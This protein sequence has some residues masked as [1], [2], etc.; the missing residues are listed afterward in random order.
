MFNLDSLV[1]LCNTFDSMTWKNY[2]DRCSLLTQ[3]T[4]L[5]R[6]PKHGHL[7]LSYRSLFRP[8]SKHGTVGC[9]QN[10]LFSFTWT[11]LYCFVRFID[12]FGILL[13]Y[14]IFHL[15]GLIPYRIAA[16]SP[17]SQ[18]LLPH[19]MSSHIFFCSFSYKLWYNYLRNRRKQVKGRVITDPGYEDVNNAFERAL[20]FMHKVR[21]N[22][23]WTIRLAEGRPRFDPRLVMPK[24]WTMEPTALCTM[25]NM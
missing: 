22:C 8:P 17:N 19:I 18:K 11:V 13:L 9:L 16:I 7:N 3:F 14:H 15:E 21:G 24:T 23:N 25:F 2:W 6:F 20:V 10:F 5:A 12:S 1:E 4:S